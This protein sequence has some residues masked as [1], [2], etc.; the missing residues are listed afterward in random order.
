M[1]P[2]RRISTGC[3]MP[4]STEARTHITISAVTQIADLFEAILRIGPQDYA[5]L[6]GFAL[7]GHRLS[8]ATLA[9]LSNETGIK[10]ADVTVTSTA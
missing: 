8:K 4:N 2:M 9:A 10:N 1:P 3:I 7:R 5:T 6:R